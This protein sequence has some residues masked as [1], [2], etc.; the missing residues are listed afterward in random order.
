MSRKKEKQPKLKTHKIMNRPILALIL[1]PL[2]CMLISTIFG[3]I[4]D[5]IGQSYNPDYIGGAGVAIGALVTLAI[6]KKWFKGEFEGNL[7]TRNLGKG[8]LLVAP[9]IVFFIMNLFD[10]DFSTVTAG[11]VILAVLEG[12]GPGIMEE[13]AFRGLSGSNFMRVWRDE[14][15]FVLIVTLTSILFGASHLFNIIA[16]AG[17][18]ISL[19]QAI[20]AFGFGVLFC[21][22]YFRSGTLWPTMIMHT[23]IDASAFLN[24]G[25]TGV[26]ED[27]GFDPQMIYLALIGIAFGALGYYYIRPAKRAEMIDIWSRKWANALPIHPEE[28]EVNE[29]ENPAPEE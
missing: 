28:T 16:G 25:F 2:F 27:S 9:A 1:M 26:L 19:V 20:Y 21:A 8:L 4:I 7:T 17:G 18:A 6:Y 10:L 12:A 22:V 11:A 15:K 23:L 5:S 3:G 14:K 13:V 29:P 24:P